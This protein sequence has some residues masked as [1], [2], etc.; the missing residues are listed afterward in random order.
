MA[1]SDEVT[2]PP[3]KR[4]ALEFTN[5]GRLCPV[6]LEGGSS[7]Q[8]K[9]APLVMVTLSVVPGQSHLNIRVIAV[10]KGHEE[11]N[12]GAWS[13]LGDR[14]FAWTHV[15]LWDCARSVDGHRL[16][17]DMSSN[18]WSLVPE[19]HVIVSSCPCLLMIQEHICPRGS[20][21][22]EFLTPSFPGAPFLFDPDQH[23]GGLGHSMTTHCSPYRDEQS[24]KRQ[25]QSSYS[26]AFAS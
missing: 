12:P 17:A 16:N 10:R 11:S 20:G 21:F 23:I 18:R 3:C 6:Q 15:Q 26:H 24:K 1:T 2:R 4:I 13:K 8:L 7:K 14:Q 5:T 25:R 9:T 22:L 19:Y